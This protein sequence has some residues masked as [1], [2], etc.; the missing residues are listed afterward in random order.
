M[1][2][3]VRHP[4]KFRKKAVV[5]QSYSPKTR[6]AKIAA[7]EMIFMEQIDELSYSKPTSDSQNF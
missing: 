4:E 7:G 5:P 6:S 1:E 3:L 2:F